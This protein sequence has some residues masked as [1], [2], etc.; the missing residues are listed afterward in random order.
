MRG[1]M[2]YSHQ[3]TTAAPAPQE[4]N[5]GREVRHEISYDGDGRAVKENKRERDCERAKTS[6]ACTEYRHGGVA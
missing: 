6:Q 5:F 3:F 1:G 2:T 4:P